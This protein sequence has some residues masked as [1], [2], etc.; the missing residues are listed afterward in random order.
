MYEFLQME[1]NESVTYFF[2]KNGK[3]NQDVWKSVDIKKFSDKDFEIIGSKV[4]SC[5]SRH[6]RIEG[7]VEYDKIRDLR[8]S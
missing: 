3:L 7:S 1:D 2:T 8:G 6:R 5:G 4:R